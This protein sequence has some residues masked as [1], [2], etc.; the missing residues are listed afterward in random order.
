MPNNPHFSG[1]LADMAALHDQKNHDIVGNLIA[2][3]L[4]MQGLE[5]S[6]RNFEDK[7]LSEEDTFTMLGN[8]H[9]EIVEHTERA[10]RP[11]MEN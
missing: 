6:K 5:P 7:Y 8:V 10:D 3:V 9:I 11:E 4:E 2:E 1:L